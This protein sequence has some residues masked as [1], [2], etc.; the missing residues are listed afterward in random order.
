MRDITVELTLPFRRATAAG[1]GQKL[2]I[3]AAGPQHKFTLPR[4]DACEVVVPDE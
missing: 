2:R 4:L 1:M 3:M